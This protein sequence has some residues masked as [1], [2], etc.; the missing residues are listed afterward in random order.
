VIA[1]AELVI[2]RLQRAGVIRCAVAIAVNV[3][4]AFFGYMILIHG[5]C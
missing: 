4:P 2:A 3:I 5:V 1:S